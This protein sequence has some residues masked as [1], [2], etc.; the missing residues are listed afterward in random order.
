M[1][2][3]RGI[4]PILVIVLVA[5]LV[6]GGIYAA[7]KTNNGVAITSFEQCAAAGYPIMES[8]PR[9]CAV[10]SGE[11]FTEVIV[12]VDNDAASCA[13]VLCMVGTTCVDGACIPNEKVVI[14]DPEEPTGDQRVYGTTYFVSRVEQT[15]DGSGKSGY[16]A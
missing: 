2:T 3:Q 1:N 8:Y 10:P 6:G 12:E 7:V 13:A 9:Q 11:R 16:Y 5:L 4:A 14:N 15:G